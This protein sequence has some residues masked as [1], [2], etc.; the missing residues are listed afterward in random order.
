MAASSS[1]LASLGPTL[2]DASTVA[3]AAAAVSDCALLA[4]RTSASKILACRF[5]RHLIASLN[6][7]S[8]TFPNALS[9]AFD[10]AMKS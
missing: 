4:A 2:G 5:R 7:R 10:A 9:V 8:S 3:I 1:I 6:F